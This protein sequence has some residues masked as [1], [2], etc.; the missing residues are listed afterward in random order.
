MFKTCSQS[1]IKTLNFKSK[2][3]MTLLWCNPIQINFPANVTFPDLSK[4]SESQKFSDVSRGYKTGSLGQ[5]GLNV[6][7]KLVPYNNL[8]FLLITQS[9]L[10]LIRLGTFDHV[11]I[12]DKYSI[13]IIS[14]SISLKKRTLLYYI[15]MFY[16]VTTS[17]KFVSPQPLYHTLHIHLTILI[18]AEQ[19]YKI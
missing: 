14:F 11:L 5:N 1:P 13:S 9:M 12:A 18:H 7:P 16:H 19:N 17:L 6:N 8:V 4:T 10:V 2:T 3:S 15:H